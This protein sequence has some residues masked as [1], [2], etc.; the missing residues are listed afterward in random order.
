MVHAWSSILLMVQ[1]EV[2]AHVLPD[3]Q[4]AAP[5]PVRPRWPLHRPLW[6]A[7]ARRQPWCRLWRTPSPSMAA[8]PSCPPLSVRADL[9]LCLGFV[10]LRNICG[11]PQSS[12]LPSC[13]HY[14]ADGL[15][16]KVQVG[17][18]VE[19][20]HAYISCKL[21][22]DRT[23]LVITEPAKSISWCLER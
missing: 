17:V 21:I 8:A 2:L 6:A 1:G 22:K 11:V 13:H 7:A 18:E 20:V 15:L 9:P 4:R 5:H 10:L 14:Q 12:A 3:A 23:V 19:N 16:E